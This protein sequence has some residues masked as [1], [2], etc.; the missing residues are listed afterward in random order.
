MRKILAGVV[1]VFLLLGSF[2]PVAAQTAAM[3]VYYAGPAESSV[4]TAL[5]LAEAFTLV[6]DPAQAQVFVLD[7]EIPDPSGIAARVSAG[8]GLVLILGPEFDQTSLQALLGNSV[9]LAPRSEPLGLV[10]QPG[11]TDPIAAGILWSSAPQVRE[12][13]ALEGLAL[14]PLVSGYESQET[15]LGRTTLGQ[16]QAFVL[17][18]AL[19]DANPQ[20][21]EWPYFNYL[22][23]SL[24]TRAAG[25]T[26][27]SF[28]DY[29]A[30][31][32]PHARERVIL[33][34]A[35]ALLL[36]IAATVFILVRRYS[37]A[38]PEAL[39]T[40]VSNREE[41]EK[42]EAGTPWERI[43][44]HRPLG[45]F[46]FAMMMGLMLFIPL[47]I[48][49]NLILPVYILPSAQAMGIYGRVLQFF[50][51]VWSLFDMG[52]SQAHIKYFSEHRV[53]TP[54]RAVQYAQFFVWWQALTGA[55]QVALIT[56]VAGTLMP[57]SALAL[58]TWAVITHVMIQIPGFYMI[59]SDSLTAL[60]R[61]D[62][63]QI[64]DMTTTLV[65]PMITQPLLISLLVWWGRSNPVFG[66]AMGGVVGL[67]VAAYASAALSFAF[68]L[69][70]YRRIGYNAKLLF[71][72][73]FDLGIAKEALKYG[74]FIVVGGLLAGLGSSLE[75][76]VIQTRLVNNNEVLGN[77][78]QAN[79]FIY[80]FS[81][82]LAL[83]GN[84]MPSI[85]E[86]ISHGRR[87][88][89][90]YYSAMAYKYGALS[91]AFIA[92]ILLATADRFILGASGVEF[93]RASIYVIPL[94]LIGALQFTTWVSDIVMYGANRTRLLV[95]M[96]IIGLAIQF[97][98]EWPLVDSLQ[99]YAI[100]LALGASQLA[101]GVV[102]FWLNHKYSFPQ[103]FY[104]W[105]S[106]AAPLLAAAAHFAVLRWV[107]G[108]IWQRDEITSILIF[109]IGLLPSYPLYAFFYG[110][111]GGWDDGTLE[112]FKL[113]ASLASFL[114]PM[115]NLF[116]LATALGAR[117]SLLHNRFPVSIRP[118]AMAEAESL[119]AERVNL[120]Q[121]AG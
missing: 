54:Q 102:G 67:G 47:I 11:S 97:G 33:Y 2:V 99:I 88:L 64:I 53:N 116:Y 100:I 115:A 111:F 71:M 62:Y 114:R 23:Y 80:A 22:V 7:G 31:P 17:S 95:I 77:Y 49:E 84:T 101:R 107:T 56:A 36:V 55:V 51:L 112:E 9:R 27:L 58:Y 20:F 90:K 43:G 18:V 42:R 72:A 13:A 5:G 50:P 117:I 16:G 98:L 89:S 61:F 85:S 70:L 38:H 76:V 4:H 10:A 60:Q 26:A 28:A 3:R 44:F 68:G 92:A 103:R 96:P 121:Q 105:Q 15:I 24:A 120:V 52:T 118:E 87:V 63:C 104:A 82:L 46:M 74:I 45:G 94:I 108:L 48:Y 73:H 29:P 113:G 75:V 65:I 86:A 83:Y 106:L 119:T 30:S 39:N 35:M 8:A 91:S 59:M 32:V 69:W 25:G 14:E 19:R 66:G 57:N 40:L 79:N 109:F 34:L 12:R 78:S 110:L 81:V 21:R 93:E 41:F 1:A 6:S 37:L